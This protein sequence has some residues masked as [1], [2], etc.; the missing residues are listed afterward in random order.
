MV[1]GRAT[2]D[3]GTKRAVEMELQ[4]DS[5][6]A[7]EAYERLIAGRWPWRGPCTCGS[8]RVCVCLCV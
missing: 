1:V 2:K 7:A 6:G 5:K 4:G 8:V 3:E